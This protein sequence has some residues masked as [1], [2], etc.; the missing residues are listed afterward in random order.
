M[1]G[2]KSPRPPIYQ[3]KVTL[4]GAR[5]PIWRRIQVPSNVTLARLH[6]VIQVSMGW[7]NAHLHQFTISGVGYGE[8]SPDDWESVKDERR[9]RLSAVVRTEKTKFLYDYDFGDGWDHEILVEK[10]LPNE[11]GLE[12]AICL[13]GAR[14]CPPEDVGGVWGYASFLETIGDPDHPEHDEMLEWVGGDFDPE[15][16]DAEATTKALKSRL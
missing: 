5:P 16:F 9:F 15:A 14:A 7:Y 2:P 11:A 3:L 6:R 12:Q 1:P 10:I 4:K 8:P 13:K